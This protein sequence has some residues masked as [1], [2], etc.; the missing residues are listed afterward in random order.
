MLFNFFYFKLIVID[1]ILALLI[2]IKPIL[3]NKHNQN[4]EKKI[5]YLFIW[6]LIGLPIFFTFFFKINFFFLNIKIFFFFIFINTITIYIYFE[7]IQNLLKK[8]KSFKYEKIE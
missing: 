8:K 4:I 2:I 7:K 3:N 5:I 1:Y 6:I